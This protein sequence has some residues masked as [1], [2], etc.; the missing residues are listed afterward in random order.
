MQR[1]A[2]HPFFR[3]NGSKDRV[4]VSDSPIHV[5]GEVFAQHGQIQQGDLGV[6]L[7]LQPVDD[8]FDVQAIPGKRRFFGKLLFLAIGVFPRLAERRID[9]IRTDQD[10]HD[11]GPT[12]DDIVQTLQQV[13]GEIAVDARVHEFIAV[14]GKPPFK[15]LDVVR[16]HHAVRDAVAGTDDERTRGGLP[17]AF[18]KGAGVVFRRTHPRPHL[19][20]FQVSTISSSISSRIGMPSLPISG[21]SGLSLRAASTAP[22]WT[23]TNRK[24]RF[25]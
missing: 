23:A 15:H 21:I 18:Q 3:C 20:N 14:R 22:G 4:V 24:P 19:E 16:A 5:A 6:G 11:I 25:W 9:I 1:Q 2:G 12:G 17:S 8:A 10:G 13:I 7:G